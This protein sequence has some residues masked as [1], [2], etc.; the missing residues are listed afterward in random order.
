MTVSQSS[1]TREPDELKGSSP[2][3]RGAVGKV[4]QGNSLAAY[5]TLLLNTQ[6]RVTHEVMVYRGT[7]NTIPVR[8]AELFKEAIRVNAASLILSHSHPS[9]EPLPSPVIWR[10]SQI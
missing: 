6:N 9:G 1:L 10:K 2:V 8:L 4:P 3:R 7:L 5:P